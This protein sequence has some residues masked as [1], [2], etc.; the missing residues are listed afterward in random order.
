M[1]T[2]IAQQLAKNLQPPKGA[3]GGMQQQPPQAA[4]QQAAPQQ[5]APQAAGMG[6][7]PPTG[8]QA[9]LQS[10]QNFYGQV[11]NAPG[12]VGF[13][14]YLMQAQQ[15]LAGGGVGGA[16]GAGGSQLPAGQ[17]NI[18]QLAKNLAQR[19]GLPLGRGE[20]VDPS[21]NFL[22]TPEQLASASG[23]QTTVGEAS[24]LMNYIGQSVANQQNIQQQNKGIAALSQGVGLVQSRARGSLAAMQSG[25]YRDIADMYANQEYEAADFSYF[26][27]KEQLEMQIELE[28]RREKR[29]KKKGLFGGIG[30]LVGGIAGAVFGGPV[31]ASIGAGIGGAVGGGAGEWF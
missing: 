16:G 7:L 28:R 21:G 15:P 22:V 12:G 6:G 25:Y 3:V 31:G 27:E 20:L 9:Q 1:P 13:N 4:G 26:I 17:L 19:Y 11:Q 24:A 23:G 18:Q 2:S 8:I 14:P 30:Q 5:A 29:A 10:L